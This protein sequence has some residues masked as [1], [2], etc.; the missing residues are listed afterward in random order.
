MLKT[1][2]IVL[3]LLFISCESPVGPD[4]NYVFI[5]L[6]ESEI[7]GGTSIYYC[8]KHAGTHPRRASVDMW[9]S[10][11][12]VS[13]ATQGENFSLGGASFH[14]KTVKTDYIEVAKN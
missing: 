7:V 14:C 1:F 10:C 12:I 5:K 3:V 13:Y 6:H 2:L 11:R 9:G 4:L 8:G